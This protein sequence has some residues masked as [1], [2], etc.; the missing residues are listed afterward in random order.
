MKFGGGSV[1]TTTALTQVV[2][3]ILQAR[4]RWDNLVVVASALEGVTDSL[5]EAAQLA[6]ISNQRGY[7]RIV[8]TIRTRHL[9]LAE[10][11]PLS[12]DKRTALQADIDQL[13]F[14]MLALC[15]ALSENYA[16]DHRVDPAQQDAII[17]TGEKLAARII[18]ALLREN[19]LRGVALDTT[20]LI[21]TDDT[22]GNALPDMEATGQR[23]RETLIPMLARDIIPVITG[24]IGGTPDG[25]P[26]TL[27]R[28]GSDYSASILAA[29]TQ[30][31]E[32]WLWADVDGLMTADP[33]QLPDARVIP[34][35]SYSEV[36][37]LAYFGAKILHPRM[38]KPLREN[39]IPLIVKNVF[40]PQQPGTRIHKSTSDEGV[41]IKAVTSISGIALRQN[42]NRP[43][44]D[45]IG[46]VNAVFTQTIKTETEVMITAQSAQSTLLTFVV[47]THAGPDATRN[48]EAALRAMLD[49]KL[50]HDKWQVQPV[51]ILT[52]IAA[53]MN[54][55]PARISTIFNALD[56]IPMLGLS[57]GPSSC[58]LSLVLDPQQIDL[59][60]ERLHPLT[61]A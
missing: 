6:Q 16:D 51:V 32:L 61:D 57:Q 23:I 48:V 14:D 18:A 7:R 53:L 13:L 47:P 42:D 49:E 52:V 3:I 43:L 21:I 9:S 17:G 11:L 54:R 39:G 26:T 4:E 33:H 58:S 38:V 34:S 1:A 15:E 30:A 44:Q 10:A 28:G 40:K 56:D 12:I 35:L 25:Q 50:Q 55:N 45:I 24:F 46:L 29:S 20:Q 27:G 60:L 22:F 8:A 36:S 31:E 19:D 5:I 41:Y 59:A 2:G 37:E